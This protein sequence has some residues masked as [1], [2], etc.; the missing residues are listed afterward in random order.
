MVDAAL[1]QTATAA[2]VPVDAAIAGDAV[3]AAVTGVPSAADVPDVAP[4]AEP[5]APTT[6]SAAPTTGPAGDA[7]SLPGLT[8][9]TDP[10]ATTHAAQVAAPADPAVPAAAPAADA[11]PA[12]ATTETA[13]PATTADSGTPGDAS[14]DDAGGAPAQQG[15]AVLAADAPETSAPAPVTG[16]V[17]GPTPVATAAPSV[18]A[19]D[20]TT[21]SVAGQPVGAQVAR[22]VAVLR[23]AADGSHTMTLVLTPDTLGPVAVEVTVTKGALDLTLRGA[24]EHGRAALLDA[25]P[26]LRRDLEQAGLSVT[27]AQVDRDTGGSR[28]FDQS[29]QSGDRQ[30]AFGD[31]GGHSRGDNRS[32]PWLGAADSGVSGPTP[33]SQRSTSSG[34]DV[35]V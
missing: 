33:M 24:H 26:D 11:A 6:T 31:R 9:V 7:S 25:L 14:S 20:G 3:P 2:P 16:P 21:D 30:Q 12:S 27:R 32:R 19:V 10:A 5:V 22:Q 34:V 28:F 1:P 29:A 15:S 13:V 23:G 17:A 8:V 18:A 4:A 35:R